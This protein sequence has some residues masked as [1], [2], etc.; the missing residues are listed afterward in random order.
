MSPSIKPHRTPQSEK[1]PLPCDVRDFRAALGPAAMQRSN[2]AGLLGAMANM[3]DKG[4][5][6]SLI[7]VNGAYDA[8]GMSLKFGTGEEI[9][10]SSL[11]ANSVEEAAGDLVGVDPFVG[12]CLAEGFA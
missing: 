5:A 9:A 10:W 1:N 8:R 12:E 3:T 7:A 6:A 4:K 11:T 2:L